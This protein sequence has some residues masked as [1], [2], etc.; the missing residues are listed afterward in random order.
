HKGQKLFIYEIDPAV[1]EYAK[2]PFYFTYLFLAKERGVDY[3][4][5]QGDGRLGIARA[6]DKSFKLLFV[7]AFS[8]DAIPTHLVT[9]EALNLY[10]SKL[11][12]DG[13]I[14]FHISNRY[15]DL[16]P[17]LARAAQ[18]VGAIAITLE[19]EADTGYYSTWV[20]M[21]KEQSVLEPL[22]KEK[23]GR[24]LEPSPHFRLWTDDY[25]SPLLVRKANL[26]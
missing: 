8:S 16:R 19:K 26:S 2:N 4:L 13:V 25:S 1:I 11:R 14:A 23:G 20:L 3:E 9:L 6:S 18:E 22:L 7:D 21:S 5:I 10:L 17:V 12:S 24:P 15:F